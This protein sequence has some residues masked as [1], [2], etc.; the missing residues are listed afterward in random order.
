MPIR[1]RQTCPGTYRLGGMSYDEWKRQARERIDSKSASEKNLAV[2]E[3]A[4]LYRN[5]PNTVPLQALDAPGFTEKFKDITGNSDT[6]KAI[7]ESAV[8]ILKHRN[9]TNGEDL[10]LI[11]IDS[12]EVFH[13]HNRSTSDK[14]IDYD[15]EINQAIMDAHKAG[16]RIVTIHNHPNGLPPT[17]DDGSSA[18][19]HE[20]NMGVAVGHNLEVWTYGRTTKKCSTEFCKEVHSALEDKLKYMLEINDSEWYNHLNQ[21]GM[22]IKK[23]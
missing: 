1:I 17:L 12:S 5:N 19:V 3:R 20:Y 8:E 13:R 15:D 14:G 18:F 16:R 22:G 2:E 6:D 7:Y 4:R 11:D 9:G 10:Y 21:Y 23:L